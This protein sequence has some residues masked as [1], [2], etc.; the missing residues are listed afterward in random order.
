MRT[1]FAS[2]ALMLLALAA[3]PSPAQEAPGA[4]TPR[5]Y[6]VLLVGNSL[7]YTNNMPAMLRAIGAAEGTPIVTETF[8]APGGTLNERLI[9]GYALAAL[10]RG[11]HDVV[12]LQ[13]QGGNLA[14]CMTKAQRNA[15]CAASRRAYATFAEHARAKGAKVLLFVSWGPDRRWDSRLRG[16]IGAVA[17]DLDV[18]LFDA[19]GALDALRR[20]QPGSQPLPDGN[21]PSIQAS[22]LLAL[23]LYRDITGT[24]PSARDLQIRAPLLPFNTDVATNRPLEVQP[25]LGDGGNV[26][27]VPAALIAP[28]LQALPKPEDANADRD[29]RRRH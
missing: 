5:Q 13:E 19:A 10:E 4:T 24:A 23:T 8:A 14:A 22:L 9:D 1:L 7:T 15:P 18:T 16:S 3:Q 6:R 28:L 21:H 27:L 26:T 25:G 12:V 2:I 20:A 11:P 29:S 17:H